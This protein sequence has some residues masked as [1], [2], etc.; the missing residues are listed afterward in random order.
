MKQNIF[1]IEDDP[2]IRSSLKELLKQEGYEVITAD[3]AEQTEQLLEGNKPSLFLLDV[4]LPDGNGFD[5]YRSLDQN[6]PVIFLTA[7]DD[8]GSIIHGLDL[9]AADYITKPFRPAVLLARIRNILGRKE[10][11][12]VMEIHDLSIDLNAG[13]VSREGKK[14]ELSPMEYRLL[15]IFAQNR[16][17]LLSREALLDEIVEISGDYVNDNTLNVYIKRLRHKIETDPVHPQVI[18][19]VR[20]LGYRMP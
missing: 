19:T 20:G 8:E 16:G 14:I 17:K 4:R 9:G 10:E 18:E 5:L 2:S 12:N 6:V 11:G 1:L 3:S 15:E 13:K 7:S